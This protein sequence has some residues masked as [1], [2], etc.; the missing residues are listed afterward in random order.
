MSDLPEI[1]LVVPVY[2]PPGQDGQL[3]EQGCVE[4]AQSWSKR[5]MYQGVLKLYIIADDCQMKGQLPWST[6]C[7]E[8]RQ[9]RAGL[10]GCLNKGLKL[11]F[12][13][14]PLALHLVDD[15]TLLRAYDLT[16][17]AMMLM[18]DETI[19]A[20]RLSSPY[21]GCTGTIEPRKYGWV[22]RL[23]KHNLAGGLRPS[24]YHKRF[25]DAYGW[26]EEG[27]TSHETERIFNEK[28]CQTEGPDSVLAL[29]VPWGESV[30]AK[31]MLGQVAPL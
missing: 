13:F 22:V 4:A 12:E 17:W 21:P 23:N 31:I 10:G 19:G 2:L 16:P 14:S 28:F 20:V 30:G 5:L 6:N 27:Q 29:P 8:F 18:E 9:E 24:L 1:N 11:A 3:R 7:L 25:F 26:F 15:M